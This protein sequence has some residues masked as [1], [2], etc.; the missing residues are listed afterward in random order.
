MTKNSIGD[1]NIYDEIHC[2]FCGSTKIYYRKEG[3]NYKAAF[4]GTLFLSLWGLLFGIFCRKRMKCECMDCGG[5]FS[6]YE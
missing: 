6:Y 4:W 5:E 1:M 3:F 2:P